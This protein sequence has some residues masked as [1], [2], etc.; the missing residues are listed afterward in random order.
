MLQPNW[1][2]VFVTCLRKY[3]KR[4]QHEI[5]HLFSEYVEEQLTK[6]R[7][8][9]PASY[10]KKDMLDLSFEK[11][12]QDELEMLRKSQYWL[13][14]IDLKTACVIFIKT[15]WPLDPVEMVR[16]VCEKVMLNQVKRIC[17][18]Q[19]L[20]PITLTACATL[21]DLENLA[22]KVLTPY[23]HQNDLKPLKFAIRPNFRN[24]TKLT[25][26]HIIRIIASFVGSPHKVDLKNYDVLIM[27]EVFKG[28]CGISIV[29]DFDK[30]K[31]L[32][33]ASIMESTIKEMTKK[34]SSN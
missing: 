10:F 21:L 17:W 29:R 26:E 15:R 3:E 7:L 22:K 11:E 27:V 32:N 28:I 14:P 8:Y 16:Y 34:D 6:N 19:R 25:R 31:K 24:H 2:G 20:T 5:L 9:E 4:A 18:S 12:I 23:F 13:K 33:I 1:S 30:L